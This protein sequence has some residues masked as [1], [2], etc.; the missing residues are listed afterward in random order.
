MQTHF[1]HPWPLCQKVVPHAFTDSVTDT[2]QSTDE[3]WRLA[4]ESRRD[5]VESIKSQDYLMS[6]FIFNFDYTVNDLPD[7]DAMLDSS[8]STNEFRNPEYVYTT[9]YGAWDFPMQTDDFI[10]P[11]A[12]Y[13]IS[14]IHK[15]GPI[16]S[17][18]LLTVNGKLTWTIGWS[19]RVV[20]KKTAEEFEDVM[21][22]ILKNA[23]G[24]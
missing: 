9:S 21:F 11:C 23:I 20:S 5:I 15:T 24:K 4:A 17:Q 6:Y 18:Q 13:S 2:R 19:Q 10:K 1:W 7:L 14:S 16:F 8:K 3:F 22:T 12:V